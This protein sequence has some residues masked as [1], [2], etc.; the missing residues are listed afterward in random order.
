MTISTITK[1]IIGTVAGLSLIVFIILLVFKKGK[2]KTREDV[3]KNRNLT[4][5]D[6]MIDNRTG[7]PM[8]TS[9]CF[10]DKAKTIPVSTSSINVL[11]ISGNKCYDTSVKSYNKSIN[12]D[13]ANFINNPIGSIGKDGKIFYHSDDD[14]VLHFIENDAQCAVLNTVLTLNKI[15]GTTTSFLNKKPT[16]NTS[17]ILDTCKVSGFDY[18]N[19]NDTMIVWGN[20]VKDAFSTEVYKSTDKGI[21]FSIL[22]SQSNYMMSTLSGGAINKKDGQYMMVVQYNNFK[23]NQ[24]IHFLISKNGG[25]DWKVKNTISYKDKPLFNINKCAMSYTGQYQIVGGI[26]GV[27]ISTNYGDNFT[28]YLSDINVGSVCCTYSGEYI[29]ISDTSGDHNFRS[30][31]MG[32]DWETY[33]NKTK[34]WV[35]ACSFDGMIVYALTVNNEVIVSHD[36]G[37]S[38]MFH[39][40]S[41]VD[42]HYKTTNCRCSPK[43]DQILINDSS[44]PNSYYSDDFMETFTVV[45]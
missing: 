30:S 4:C 37:E 17:N 25:K 34:R 20:S 33:I 31:N 7:K 44:N 36:H 12:D 35:Q 16:S 45:G 18:T 41:S 32:V 39:T 22:I 13:D 14:T 8:T 43:G 1:I 40:K 28:N 9:V 11:N 27:Y 6:D 10:V 38:Y 23:P 29:H 24:T 26:D 42:V 5:T 19:E 21:S 2:G 15:T 3:I